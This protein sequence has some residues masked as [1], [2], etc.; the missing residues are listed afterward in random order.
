MFQCPICGQTILI[1]KLC[2]E[3]ER[4]RQLC[5]IYGKETVIDVLNK[6]LV[7]SE[8]DLDYTD[9]I[10]SVYPHL[11]NRTIS[12]TSRNNDNSTNTE[13]RVD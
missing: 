6:A 3:C 11:R 2:S 9:G 13:D 1:T 5:K 12:N 7:V 4:I 10:H 8:D